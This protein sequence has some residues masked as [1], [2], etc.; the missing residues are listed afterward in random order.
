MQFNHK[1]GQ[2]NGNQMGF[3]DWMGIF[4]KGNFGLCCFFFKTDSLDFWIELSFRVMVN[5][6]S[7]IKA[8]C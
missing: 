2:K 4:Y 3:L 6:G 8:K 1:C 7:L 5:L